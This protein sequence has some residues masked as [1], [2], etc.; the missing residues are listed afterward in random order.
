MVLGSVPREERSDDDD[1]DHVHDDSEWGCEHLVVEEVAES[2]T[3][4]EWTEHERESPHKTLT[5][6]RQEPFILVAGP[7]R[8]LMGVYG[9][10]EY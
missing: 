10:E 5:T 4:N 7:C 9:N 1:V 2:D 8:L 3:R 6:R